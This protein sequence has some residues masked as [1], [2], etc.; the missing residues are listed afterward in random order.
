MSKARDVEAY[1]SLVKFCSM[2]GQTAPDFESW[3]VWSHKDRF[4]EK[5]GTSHSGPSSQP[6]PEDL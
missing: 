4:P 1:E 3:S 5:A 6:S 2:I